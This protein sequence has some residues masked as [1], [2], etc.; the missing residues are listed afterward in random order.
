MQVRELAVPGVFEFTPRLFPDDRGLFVAPFQEAVFAAACGHPLHLA[1]TNHSVSRRAVVRGLHFSDVPPGQSK[2]VYC[3]RGALLDVAVDVRVGSPTF[4]SWDTV[5]LDSCTYR[6]L[7]LP[8]GIGHAFVALEEETVMT[9]LCSTP[10]TPVMERTVHPLDP[11]LGLP[12][13][14]DVQPALSDKDAA[15]PTLAEAA[16]AGILPTW[17]ACQARYAELR[18]AAGRS[19]ARPPVGD[20]S[21]FPPAGSP[22]RGGDAPEAAGHEPEA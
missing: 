19:G 1:Q 4:G 6:A 13:P 15:A 10:Y 18:A 5:Q 21:G 16:S 12:W 20:P 11:A 9:Y 7:Y 3:P 17:D 8:E 14:P 22:A 2:Y